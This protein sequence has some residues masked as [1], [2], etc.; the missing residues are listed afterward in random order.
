MQLA[1]FLGESFIYFPIRSVSDALML[2]GRSIKQ[3]S[4]ANDGRLTAE[5][6]YKSKN[7]M[8]PLNKA[9]LAHYYTLT[10]KVS[11]LNWLKETRTSV[12]NS[13]RVHSEHGQVVG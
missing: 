3:T 7:S 1:Y 8:V 2:K 11:R 9:L 12:I 6:Q 10:E 5:E 4:S 13:I